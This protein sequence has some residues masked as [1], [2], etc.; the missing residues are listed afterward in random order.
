MTSHRFPRRPRRAAIV[1]FLLACIALVAAPVAGAA[2]TGAVRAAPVS[3]SWAVQP[4]SGV[5]ADGRA[6]FAYTDMKPGTRIADHLLIDNFSKRPVTFTVY[7]VDGIT[8]SSG[9]IG[10]APA[11][12]RR[13]DIAAMVH[14]GRSRVTVPASGKLNVPFTVD[15]PGN[16]T[17]GDHVGG[18]IAS[19]TEALNGGKVARE[20]RVGVA[21]YLR[22][23]GALHPA[24]GIESV[25]SSGYHGT[26]NP[27]GGG[28]TTVSY[29]VRNTG[30]VRLGAAQR[31]AV[32][33][34]FGIPLATVHPS[35]EEL[36]PGG[37]VRVTA[38]LRGIFPLLAPLGVHISVTPTVV[39]GSPKLT[40]P[41]KPATYAIGLPETPWEQLLL[42]LVVV[43]IVVLIVRRIRTR[44]RRQAAAVAAAL[45]QGRREAQLTGV[46]ARTP[47]DPAAPTD[48]E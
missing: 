23:A 9:S 40:V 12:Q 25:S 21:M 37:S 36:L 29:T 5:A 42:L 10:L 33:G 17:P 1:A 39:P 2:P 28:S 14:V 13:I 20:D 7:A 47:D 22:V 46:G 24:L 45:E 48:P 3:V 30:N 27:F 15:V 34:L 32:T 18:V 43:A 11:K 6:H 38:R 4:S 19:V 16:A 44:R 26:P 41:L 31:V 8:T 35:S